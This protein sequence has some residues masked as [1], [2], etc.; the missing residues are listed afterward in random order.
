MR[1]IFTCFIVVVCLL[2]SVCYASAYQVL[3]TNVLNPSTGKTLRGLLYLPETHGKK[4]PLVICAHELGCNYRMGWPQYGEA[5]APEGIAVYTFDFAGGGPK[6]QAN[7]APGNTS[8][9]ETTEMSVMTEVRDLEVVL[10][11][12]KSWSFVDVNR[13]VI[14]GGSQGGCVSAITASR[15][16]EEITALVLLYPGLLITDYL[17]ER[18]TSKEDCP[19]VFNYN[20]WFNLGRIYVDDMWDCDVYADMPKFTKPVLILHGD[21]D[22][23]VPESY[24][25][26]AAE[27]YPDAEF[28]MIKDGEHG[29]S[30]AA[31]T[32]AIGYIKE[33]FR[34]TELIHD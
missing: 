21:K 29:F 20:D 28:H 2:V 7:G 24:S 19:P 26:R 31:F 18:F 34:K 8:D 17:H 25:I 14:I 6:T 23:M 12:A 4:I 16:V 9:G 13:I 10:N 11:E 15:H 33:F 5:L 1:K 3:S 30:G 32:Q 27:T 22:D